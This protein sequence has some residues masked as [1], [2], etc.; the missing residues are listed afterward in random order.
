LDD[1]RRFAVV[2]TGVAGMAA[3]WLVADR[4][5]VTVYEREAQVGGHTHTVDVNTPCGTVP[6]D[7]GFIVYNE[8]N[9]PNLTA[10][11]AHLGVETKASD[12]G[13]AVSL[14]DGALEYAGSLLGLA[15]QPANLLRRDYLRMLYDT[16]RFY[17]EA[18]DLPTH[19]SLRGSLGEYLTDNNYSE[20]FA[21]LHLLPM[22]AAI[23]SSSLDDMRSYP[24]AAFARFFAN[25]GLLKL[26]GRP[27]WRTVAGGSREYAKKLTTRFARNV[28]LNCGVKIILRSLTGV[29]IVDEQGHSDCYDGVIIASHANQALTMLGDPTAEERSLL[30]SFDYRPNKVVLHCD[31]T[32]MPKRKM[33]WSSW[34]YLGRSDQKGGED[35]CVTYW[36][37]KLQGIDKRTPVFVTLNPPAMPREETIHG[38]YS[39]AH[40]L[41][42]ERAIEAQQRLWRLQGARNTWFCG[43]YF[44]SGFHED[45]LQA[46]L[47][48]AEDATG[49]R[50]PW[51]VENESGRIALVP[52]IAGAVA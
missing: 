11:F 3:A 51:R 33:A 34:N 2:G 38:V 48:A 35:L 32:F 37:N 22:G 42:N 29:T 17:R 44:G 19:A 5:P 27:Q 25:H 41:F 13:F 52:K 23:W 6:V 1:A 12:M 20:A 43:S 18:N 30:G 10:L 47:A 49:L 9:Y 24:M 14:D 50:R 46:G 31:T 26:V 39:C 28:R 16:L 7:T 8:P 40:P 45:A 21:R 15:A 4:Y 36:M